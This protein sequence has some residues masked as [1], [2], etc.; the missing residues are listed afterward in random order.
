MI[1]IR[2]FIY[3]IKLKCCS[4]ILSIFK[5]LIEMKS[6]QKKHKI[7]LMRMFY[8]PP[9]RESIHDKLHNFFACFFFLNVS[10]FFISCFRF[11]HSSNQSFPPQLKQ[12][13]RIVEEQTDRLNRLLVDN[14][15]LESNLSDR[16]RDVSQMS[17]IIEELKQ[18]LEEQNEKIDNYEKV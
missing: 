12:Y 9:E 1:V 17:D 16:E 11:E 3:L 5:L 10:H 13:E 14:R 2:V 6:K 18:Q 15:E 8:I 4:I 7:M